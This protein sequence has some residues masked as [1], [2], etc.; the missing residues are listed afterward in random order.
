MP[1]FHR[2]L[3]RMKRKRKCVSLFFLPL[4]CVQKLKKNKNKKVLL[5]F[6]FVQ[7]LIETQVKRAT[8]AYGYEIE[9][10]LLSFEFLYL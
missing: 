10:G 6:C 3:L 2:K 4:F 5:G 8:T 1:S 7:V 9:C